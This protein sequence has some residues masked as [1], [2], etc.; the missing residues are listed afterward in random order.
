MVYSF[1]LVRNLHMFFIM[2]WADLDCMMNIYLPRTVKLYVNVKKLAGV[3]QI[4]SGNC[5]LVRWVDQT[6]KKV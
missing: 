5:L 1:K 6:C 4:D 3:F 2:L